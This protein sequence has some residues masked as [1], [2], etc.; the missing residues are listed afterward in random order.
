MSDDVLEAFREFLSRQRAPER[1]LLVVNWEGPEAVERLLEE[2]FGQLPLDIEKRHDP[3]RGDNIIV[4][5]EDEEVV[6]TSTLESLQQAVLL[7]NVDLYKTG[8]SGIEKYEAP[9]VLTALDEMLF[10]LRGFPASTKEKLLLVVMSR[11]IEKRALEV[12]EGR[13]DVAFQELSRME[14]EYGTRKVYE[15]LADSDLAVEVYGVPDSMPDLDDIEVNA[16]ETAGY[17]RSWFVVFQPPPGE[18]PAALLAIETGP[19]EWDSMWTYDRDRVERLGEIIESS[20]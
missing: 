2:T 10:T 9:D 3:D 7:V 14:D 8:L 12:G 5:I 13:L 20:F 6:A 18:E 4:L 15:R 16:G 17:R 11:F 19:N 1:E